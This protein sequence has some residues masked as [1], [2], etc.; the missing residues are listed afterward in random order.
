ME[1]I[2]VE[3]KNNPFFKRKELTL[4]L[5]H[6]TLSTPS[7]TELE[8]ILAETHKVDTS[9]VKIDYIFTK[10]GI[11]ESLAKVKILEEKPKIEIK[12]EVKME[13][14]PEAKP[15]SKPEVEKGSEKVEA[16][17]S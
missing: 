9:Q 4:V 12:A 2:V 16:Q 5:K 11:S 17:A 13:S 1:I 8:K 14:K 15:E 3:E 10:K 7:K 6:P